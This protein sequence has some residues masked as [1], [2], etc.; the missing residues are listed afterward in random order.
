MN[1]NQASMTVSSKFG[2]MVACAMLLTSSI[3]GAPAAAAEFPSKPIRLIVPF[4]AGGFTDVLAR[5]V[6]EEMAT[7]LGQ[8][9]IVENRVGA[10]GTI[11]ANYVAKATPDGYTILM[12]TPD[13]MITGP[14]LMAGVQYKPE[15]FR[16]LSLLVQQPLVLAV[17]DESPYKSVADMIEAA[18]RNPDKLTYASWGNGSSAHIAS[19]VLANSAGVSMTHVPYKGVSNAI[20]D[21]IGQRVD[22]LYV[23]MMSTVASV[24][25]GRVRPI[26]INRAERS[27]ILPEVPTLSELGYSAYPISL[28][29]AF[30]VPKDTPSDV[31]NTLAEAVR[32]AADSPAIRSWLEDVGMDVPALS[33]EATEEFMQVEIKNWSIAIQNAGIGASK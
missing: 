27:P 6:A 8:P 33:P 10:S 7:T 15:D 5:K 24:K 1:S 2:R 28:W 19:S 14:Q 26:A 31:V 22:S 30:G 11:G 17:S 16:Q 4:S 21:L 20:I 9:V 3:V 32:S 29:Y 12:E 13:T 23:G 18:K 25:D